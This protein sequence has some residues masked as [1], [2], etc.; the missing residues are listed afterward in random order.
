MMKALKTSNVAQNLL[1]RNFESYGPGYVLLTDITYLFFSRA[2]IKANLSVIK[3][4]FTKQV[5]AHA[6]S[7]SLEEDFVLETIEI[8]FINHKDDIHTDALLHPDQ[9]AHYTSYKFI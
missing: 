2:R 4:A 5:K 6:L 3:D 8:L 1:E 9:G 7:M